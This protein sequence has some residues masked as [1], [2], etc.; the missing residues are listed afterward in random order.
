MKKRILSLLTTLA[1]FITTFCCFTV[2]V[3]AASAKVSIFGN[4]ISVNAE[5][6]CFYTRDTD[7][8][9]NI[10]DTINQ[11]MFASDY[12]KF[13]Y[14]DEGAVIDCAEIAQ[15]LPKLKRLCIIMSDVTNLKSLAK[16]K[17]LTT[18]ELHM[19]TG[20]ENISFLR[21]MT[22]LKSFSYTDMQCT[23]I[24]PVKS[25]NR[26]KYL[27]LSVSK[28]IEINGIVNKLTRLKTLKLSCSMENLDF[29]KNLTSLTTLTV[30][31]NKLANISALEK[32]TR[33]E[34]LCLAGEYI[35]SVSVLKKIKSLKSLSLFCIEASDLKETVSGLTNLDELFMMECNLGDCKFLK[36]LVNLK[37]LGAPFCEIDDL[38]GLEKLTKLEELGLSYN[39]ISDVT[40]LKKLKKLKN[41]L[42]ARNAISDISPLKKLKKLERIVLWNNNISDFKPI[43]SMTALREL[44]CD[45]TDAAF[46][47]ELEKV[48]PDCVIE[49]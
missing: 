24:S 1:V 12:K 28:T 43:L 9:L 32:L 46:E 6:I 38:S 40:P 44:L 23:D 17:N 48:N 19:N 5:K 26:L 36:K 49:H 4:K 11:E 30:D 27:D 7:E 22:R 21:N 29:L 33:L 42:L 47:A 14:V 18:I 16:L 10:S 2:N 20:T 3:G 34:E 45:D 8:E 25:L 37:A 15:K 31:S 39:E 13:Y 41:L 35:S